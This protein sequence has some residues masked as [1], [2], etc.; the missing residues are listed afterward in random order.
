MGERAS[1]DGANRVEVP[2]L[3]FEQDTQDEC[4]EV[5]WINVVK[6]KK[7]WM[8]MM[9]SNQVLGASVGSGKY[10][11]KFDSLELTTALCKVLI[12]HGFIDEA[13]E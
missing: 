9:K 5:F 6:V 8:L 13:D 4:K 3:S 2:L 10:V 11:P 1:L 12:Q 7:P